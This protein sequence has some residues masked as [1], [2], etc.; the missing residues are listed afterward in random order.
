MPKPPTATRKSRKP[1]PTA[2]ARKPAK[3]AT[4]KPSSTPMSTSVLGGANKEKFVA[5]FLRRGR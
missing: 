4:R 3:R 1:A 5:S 2:A